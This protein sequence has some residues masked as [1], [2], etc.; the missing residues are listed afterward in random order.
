MR[1]DRQANSYAAIAP[2]GPAPTTSTSQVRRP[3]SVSDIAATGEFLTAF[4]RD[5]QRS[6]A[7]TLPVASPL[8]NPLT[9]NG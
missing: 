7:L 2:A 5:A 3:A 1:K 8:N 9:I 4:S 6:V